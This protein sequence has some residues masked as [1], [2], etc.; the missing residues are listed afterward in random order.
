MKEFFKATLKYDPS[1][2]TK[3]DHKGRIGKW[4]GGGSG[5]IIGESL[6][7]KATWDLFEDQGVNTCETEMILGVTTDDGK[8]LDIVAKGFGAVGDSAKPSLWQ[9]GASLSFDASDTKY[10]WLNTVIANWSG[11]FDMNTGVHNY[12]AYRA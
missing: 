3:L 1:H 10:S 12:K 8:R 11:E 4:L 9:M 7:G 6:S 2:T 5:E